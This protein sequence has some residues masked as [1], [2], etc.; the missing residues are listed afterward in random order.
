MDQNQNSANRAPGGQNRDKTNKTSRPK[1]EIR[2]TAE[3][4]NIDS[5][6]CEL[7]VEVILCRNGQLLE[8]QEI[9]LKEVLSTIHSQVSDNLGTAILKGR[10]D[11]KTRSRY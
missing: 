5:N 8:D 3:V 4:S 1:V 7:S 9:I 6:T 11:R 2:T 10:W